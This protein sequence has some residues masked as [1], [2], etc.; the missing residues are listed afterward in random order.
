MSQQE[1]FS[2]DSAPLYDIL[3]G[4]FVVK[5][6]LL[7][8]SFELGGGGGGHGFTFGLHTHTHTHTH[9]KGGGGPPI[10]VRQTVVKF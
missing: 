9:T 3:S 1:G 4:Q 7:S 8:T 6:K 2:T 10:S 5:N